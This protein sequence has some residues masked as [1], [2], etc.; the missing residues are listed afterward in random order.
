MSAVVIAVVSLY[1]WISLLLGGLVISDALPAKVKALPPEGRRVAAGLI[2]LLWPALVLYGICEVL[3]GVG[4]GMAQLV[5]L[6][7]SQPQLPEAR[8]VERDK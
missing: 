3:F 6:L 7:R 1:G 5:G 8:T 2:A 4:R